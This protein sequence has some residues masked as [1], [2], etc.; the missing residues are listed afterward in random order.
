MDNIVSGQEAMRQRMG[1]MAAPVGLGSQ[2][3]A[4]P[5]MGMSGGAAGV[6]SQGA[7]AALPKQQPDEAMVIVKALGD[8]LKSL[9]PKPEKPQEQPQMA[10]PMQTPQ[11]PQ[12]PSVHGGELVLQAL[13]GAVQ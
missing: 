7:A 8:R 5:S 10:Q 11:M 9:T 1:Q 4:S 3:G 12:A 13:Q 2:V 6:P